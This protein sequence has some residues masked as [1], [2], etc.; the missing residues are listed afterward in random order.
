M[1][2][3]FLKKAAVFFVMYVSVSVSASEYSLAKSITLKGLF[4][5]NIALSPR[6]ERERYGE[7]GI[8]AFQL[9]RA[10]ELSKLSADISLKANNYNLDSYNTFDQVVNV[11]YSKQSEI[12]SW[13]LSANYSRDSISTLDPEAERVDFSN[14]IDS[15]IYSSRLN[16]NWNRSLNEKNQI[17]WRANISDVEYESE[18]RS[19][20]IYGQTSL[21][22][23]YLISDRLRLQSNVAYSQVETDPSK[24]L[25]S[26]PLF[27]DALED[28]VFDLNETFLLID[29]CRSGINQIALLNEI[30]NGPSDDFESW[31]CFEER[32]TETK[33][34]T[35]Q[36]QLGI[37]YMLTQRLVLD[38]LGGESSVESEFK[39]FFLNVP[40]IGETSGQ[41]VDARNDD[42]NRG[43]VYQGSIKY[44]GESWSSGIEFSRKTSV[45]SISEL[46]LVRRASFNAQKRFNR[47]HA[48]SG[49]VGHNKQESSREAGNTFFARDQIV[50]SLRY[51]YT[52]A[53]H[54]QLT[55]VY[56]FRD[57]VIEGQEDHARSN[58]VALIVAWRPGVSQW[59]W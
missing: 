17:A 40:P 35:V 30:V 41:R 38:V 9:S 33:Q 12:G 45:N 50:A 7:T 49:S 19:D 37:Y 3:L 6:F 47:Y 4:N 36:W 1:N 27:F 48:V 8:A 56:G 26:N 58:Q 28:G 34:S 20:Y 59:S 21:L 29:L 54:W 5:D 51:N 15:R 18:F 57:Q 39:S 16:A 42:N 25:V 44:S 2:V 23:Q 14:S 11:S 31:S 52:F 13:G 53:E 55:A 22:W 10:T 46:S 24:T 32:F 43:S